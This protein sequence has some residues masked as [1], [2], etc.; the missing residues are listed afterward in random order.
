MSVIVVFTNFVVDISMGDENNSG[1]GTASS[2][3]VEQL[4]DNK[5]YENWLS[6]LMNNAMKPEFQ[7]L[8]K[9]VIR[10]R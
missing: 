1:N 6:T 9:T 7:E 10:V 8:K 5:K 4:I 3:L 2:D